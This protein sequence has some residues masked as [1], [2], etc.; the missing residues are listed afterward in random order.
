MTSTKAKI[1]ETYG[2]DALKRPVARGELYEVADLIKAG[3]ADIAK[4]T[5]ALEDGGVKYFGVWQAANAYSRGA[6][7]TH[8]GS[9]WHA[10]TDTSREP[11]EGKDWTLA[12]KS[13]RDGKDAGR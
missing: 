9:M 13:G 4:R 8:K 11:G 7:V 12:V 6:L 10:N 2:A 3:L 5:S 1:A